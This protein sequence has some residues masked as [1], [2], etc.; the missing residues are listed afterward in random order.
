M[1]IGTGDLTDRGT[2]E[3]SK[4]IRDIVAPLAAPF[5]LI[6][7][8]HDRRDTFRPVHETFQ[9]LRDRAVREMLERSRGATTS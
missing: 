3:E 8:N 4:A 1:V 7:G 2:T 5:Y 9:P 6:P